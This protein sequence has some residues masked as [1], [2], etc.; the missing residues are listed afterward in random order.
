MIP[1]KPV[2]WISDSKWAKCP[3]GMPGRLAGPAGRPSWQA[4][5]AGLAGWQARLAGP[6]GRPGRLASLAGRPVKST[7]WLQLGS[8]ECV[9]MHIKT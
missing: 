4:L 3:A 7:R 2:E 5:L 1:K 6:A 9:R 8:S